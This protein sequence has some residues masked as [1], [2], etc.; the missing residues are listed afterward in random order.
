[1]YGRVEEPPPE[2]QVIKLKELTQAKLRSTQILTNLSQIISELIQNSLDAK[3]RHID[4]GLNCEEWMCWVRDDGSGMSQQDLER[5][6]TEDDGVRYHT[7]KEY[8]LGSANSISTYGFRG[9]AL[10]S[11]AQISC[12]EIASRSLK[13]RSTWSIIRKGDQLLYKGEA[14]RWR[15]ESPGTVVCVR[16]AFFNLPV[17]RISHPSAT[18]TWDLV[19]REVETYA[20]VSPFVSFTLEDLH[21]YH[22]AG[23]GNR[24]LRIP[25]TSSPLA[26]FRQLYGRTLAERIE[27]MNE[28]AGGNLKVEGFI[29]LHGASSKIYQFLYINSH[30]ITL[31][32]LHRAID[33]QFSSSSFDL[34][35]SSRKTERKP[36]YVLNLKVPPDG[37]D[38]GLDP[39]KNVVGLQNKTSV[40]SFLTHCVRGFL[41]RNGFIAT[42]LDSLNTPGL[43]Q[44]SGAPRKRSRINMDEVDDAVNGSSLTQI[45]DIRPLRSPS[46]PSDTPGEAPPTGHST[47][48]HP[49]APT[50]VLG[51]FSGLGQGFVERRT[52][53]PTP[54]K[55]R[56]HTATPV[57][58][59]LFDALEANNSYAV[60]EP[61]VPIVYPSMIYGP[62]T[63]ECNSTH[64]AKQYSRYSADL[65]HAN[66]NQIS[67]H[68]AREDLATTKIIGQVDEKFIACL[69]KSSAASTSNGFQ[70]RNARSDPQSVVPAAVT[71]VVVDQH[72]ADERVRV[73]TFLRELCLGFLS[74]RDNFSAGGFLKIRILN[75]PKPILVTRHE[76][77]CLNEST[78]LQEAFRS[79][80]ISFTGC[81][82]LGSNTENPTSDGDIHGWGQILVETIPE[83]LSDK[84]LQEDELQDLVKGF[85]AQLQIDLPSFSSL[86]GINANQETDAEFLWL[87]ALRY[88]PRSLL[89]LVNLKAC[90][91]MPA[92]FSPINSMA[93]EPNGYFQER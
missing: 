80:G 51:A 44:T 27:T 84:L 63:T 2:G 39:A 66:Q 57:P 24:I 79:W 12:L 60:S 75:P 52:I 31:C 23:I 1:M 45:P 64:T 33:T 71:L 85:L 40:I 34:R 11:A 78:E 29:S 74:S 65:P 21:K 46:P 4:V 69:I 49:L 28:A 73:E 55:S 10:A 7:S 38:N 47:M 15:R 17:R 20:L 35:L 5:F 68:F 30:P 6:S 59:W 88:C 86:S 58:T 19:R 83:V 70:V 32:D 54:N 9:E 61:V 8:V 62:P 42:S 89:D 81:S 76:L 92:I 87:R 43:K 41:A 90:R 26:T 77:R 22:E 25:K 50:P 16:D 3:A 82:L 48:N 18:K 14:V 37:V 67:T 56:S 72:A 36:I 93:A 53:P 91:G 13:A